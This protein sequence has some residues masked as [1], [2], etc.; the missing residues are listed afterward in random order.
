MLEETANGAGKLAL[1]L[2]TR[3]VDTAR[4]IRIGPNL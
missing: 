2:G 3:T 4:P 1:I